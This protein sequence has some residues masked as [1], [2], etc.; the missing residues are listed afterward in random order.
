MVAAGNHAPQLFQ[1]MTS[2]CPVH[3]RL[4][5]P[6]ARRQFHRYR[7][8]RWPDPGPAGTRHGWRGCATRDLGDQI[9]T[10]RW[11]HRSRQEVETAAGLV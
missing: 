7:V 1:S 2:T 6:P 9:E 8:Q 10:R 4:L 11:S 3:D 5:V